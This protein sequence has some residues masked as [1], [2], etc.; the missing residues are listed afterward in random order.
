MA[1]ITSLTEQRDVAFEQRDS[2]EEQKSRAMNDIEQRYQAMLETTEQE[3]EEKL[4]T[5]LIERSDQTLKT[6]ENLNQMKSF[7]EM[8]KEA[9]VQRVTEEK[10]KVQKQAQLA[11]E[12]LEQ[13]IREDQERYSDE[14]ELIQAQ[15][16]DLEQTKS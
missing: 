5:A 7:Y 13:K 8:D 16:Q 2:A 1:E 3:Y 10:E 15:F 6:E 12:E 11:I 9:A 4:R 14:M